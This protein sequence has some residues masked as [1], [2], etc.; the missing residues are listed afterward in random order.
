MGSRLTCRSTSPGGACAGYSRTAGGRPELVYDAVGRLVILPAEATFMELRD[1]AG[2]GRCRLDPVDASGHVDAAVKTACTGYV[3]APETMRDAAAMGERT[4]A[5]ARMSYEDLLVESMRANIRLAELVI[6]KIPAILGASGTLLT[7][8]DNAGLTTRVPPAPPP[9]P[10]VPPEPTPDDDDDDDDDDAPQEEPPSASRTWINAIVASVS[11]HLPAIIEKLMKSGP[12]LF[13]GMPLGAFLD[14]RKAAPGAAASSEAPSA[15]APAASAPAGAP[16]SVE[17]PPMP[18]VEINYTNFLH[19]Y[20]QLTPAERER[21]QAIVARLPSEARDAFV[22]ELSKLS[23]PEALARVRQELRPHMPPDHGQRPTTHANRSGTASV[24][25]AA[26]PRASAVASAPAWH[27]PT[28]PSSPTSS[29]HAAPAPMPASESPI[30]EIQ[31][32]G[33]MPPPAAE[34]V[35]GEGASRAE[36]PAS[37]DEHALRAHLL[38]IWGSLSAD[39]RGQAERLVE[40]LTADQRTAWIGELASMP[41]PQATA[42]VRDLLRSL[43][44]IPSTPAIAPTPVPTSASPPTT[45]GVP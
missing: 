40:A 5:Q 37:P 31:R 44:S 13:G 28:P 10:P 22:A 12:S 8:A 7:A 1:A 21:A 41:V 27:S 2:A 39:E 26:A 32:P 24:E 35:A 3:Q 6:E 17:P 29:P 25:A 4:K 18:S 45:N 20:Q 30:G 43:Q 36:P 11:P 33:A 15:S 19:V 34:P 23:V 9:P 42:W 16:S 14:W 38:A